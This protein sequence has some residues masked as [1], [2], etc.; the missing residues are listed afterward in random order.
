MF[1][2]L[3][4]KETTTK[5]NRKQNSNSIDVPEIGKFSLW[6]LTENI[7]YIDSV[8]TEGKR[9]NTPTD[10]HNR[11]KCKQEKETV[12]ITFNSKIYYFFAWEKITWL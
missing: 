12:H 9:S 1:L 3:L 6:I 5:E 7:L 4:L 8:I 10:E 11:M 2:M